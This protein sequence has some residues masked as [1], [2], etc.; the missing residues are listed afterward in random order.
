MEGSQ[1]ERSESGSGGVNEE[2]L[3]KLRTLVSNSINGKHPLYI[4]Y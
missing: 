2:Y 3:A 4:Q 1:A